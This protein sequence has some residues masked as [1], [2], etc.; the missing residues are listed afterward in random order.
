MRDYDRYPETLNIPAL[1]DP[2]TALAIARV[3]VLYKSTPIRKYRRL[4]FWANQNSTTL[5]YAKDLRVGDGVRVE[6]DDHA[7]NYVIIGFEHSIQPGGKRAHQVS[8]WLESVDTGS[9]FTLGRS[10]LNRNDVLAF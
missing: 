10:K 7:M 1:G 4:S 6:Y 3:E 2:D 8:M 5:G 9:F